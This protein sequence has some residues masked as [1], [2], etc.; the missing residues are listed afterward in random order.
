MDN[1]V[2]YR[3]KKLHLGGAGS[4]VQESALVDEEE[5]VCLQTVLQN[6]KEQF[7]KRIAR[8]ERRLHEL[9]QKLKNRAADAGVQELNLVRF[10]P[11][12]TRK[13]N[14]PKFVDFINGLGKHD[15]LINY[16]D[17]PLGTAINGFGEAVL[18]DAG[19]IETTL[20]NYAKIVVK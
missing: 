16:L 17:A 7:K 3:K 5:Y 14:V 1:V 18:Q 19:L 6:E 11:R 13:I 9:T 4:L 10:M 12:M 8:T 2:E 15:V 20:D